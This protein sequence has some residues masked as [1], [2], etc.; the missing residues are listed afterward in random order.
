MVAGAISGA[1]ADAGRH[2]EYLVFTT[3]D[4]ELKPIEPDAKAYNNLATMQEEVDSMLL[5]MQK[6]IERMIAA[7]SAAV[8]TGGHKRGR[9]HG[10]ALIR[11]HLG[12]VDV[13]RRKQENKTLNV[14]VA[15]Q[16]DCSYS[17]VR[18]DKLKTACYSAYAL[19]SILE[20]IGIPVSVTGFTTKEY[21]RQVK[22]DF[23]ADPMREL[24]VRQ[25]A[26]LMPVFKTFSE[27]MTT[28]V[29]ARFTHAFNDYE[30][31]CGANVD[32]ES[33]LLT[34]RTLVARTE[35]RKIIMVLSDGLPSTHGGTKRCETHLKKVVHMIEESGTDIVGIGI[36]D[37]S[38]H[39]FYPKAVVIQ[40]VDDLPATVMGQLKALLMK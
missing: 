12:K 34:A 6:D 22:K 4:D 7:R 20:R 27:R 33:L 31:M 36:C 23:A 5:P 19:A 26:I 1:A 40:S 15:L 10:P 37:S 24:Y 18:N 3:D 39:K 32:G 25:E 2:S 13:F 11:A 29:K 38:V 14:A 28:E 17:M 9:L 8:W 30:D 35:A 16:V 21:S